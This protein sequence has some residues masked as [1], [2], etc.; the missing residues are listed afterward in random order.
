LTLTLAGPTLAYTQRVQ[1]ARSHR[2]AI[3][4][5]IQGVS[6]QIAL[7]ITGVGG[8]Q[9]NGIVFDGAGDLWVM[10]S[11]R[12]LLPA[13]LNEFTVADLSAIGSQGPSVTIRFSGF[14]APSQGVFDTKGNLWVSD[15]HT[16]T[17]YEYSAAQLAITGPPIVFQNLAPNV[18][19]M[20]NPALNLPVGMAFDAEG[21]LWV[22]NSGATTI[23]EF[24]SAALPT[25]PGS[26]DT[27]SPTLSCRT[28]GATQF[29]R[30]GH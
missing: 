17:I 10:A 22:A 15:Y 26:I 24:D 30:L 1:W 6:I 12:D 5:A 7:K 9:V 3:V 11:S 23:F 20:S 28:T 27:L 2:H 14:G 25:T 18:Q 19:F 4:L 13:S 29:K 16:D 21:N 8:A